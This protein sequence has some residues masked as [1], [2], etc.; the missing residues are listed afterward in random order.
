VLPE[1]V[2]QKVPKI[3]EKRHSS[4]SLKKTGI[5]T[6]GAKITQPF[7]KRAILFYYGP[8]THFELRYILDSNNGQFP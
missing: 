4:A 6:F 7:L 2:F 1:K 8:I 5:G 3:T